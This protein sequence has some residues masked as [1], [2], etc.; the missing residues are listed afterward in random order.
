MTR[1]YDILV[2]DDDMDIRE[3]LQII[4]E[5]AGYQVRLAANGQEALSA[6]QQRRPD[7][8]ILDVMMSTDTEGFDVACELKNSADYAN[9]P[10]IMLTSFME[11][12]R[13]EGPDEFQ[14]ILGEAW[15]ARWLFEK[16]VDTARLLKKLE[17]ILNT[18]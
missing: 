8:M 13:D 6:L 5:S 16:P 18:A 1:Q 4:L 2:V 9:L 14:H 7:L 10:I 15:P 3:A 17:D 12:V 11:K